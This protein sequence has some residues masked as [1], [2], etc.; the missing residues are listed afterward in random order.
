MKLTDEIGTKKIRII[1]ID[2]LK[3]FLLAYIC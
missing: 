2:F 1:W 3:G